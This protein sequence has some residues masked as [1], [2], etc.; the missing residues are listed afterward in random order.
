[1]NRLF[2][3]MLFVFAVLISCQT[4]ELKTEDVPEE[5]G[6]I[7]GEEIE[8]LYLTAAEKFISLKTNVFAFDLLRTVYRDEEEEK[9]ILLSP[10]SASLALAMLNNGAAGQTQQ[11]IQRTLGYDDI[12]REEMN[13]YFQKLITAAQEADPYV[14]F[15]S[16]NSIWTRNDF[17]VL[18]AFKEVNKSYYG[19]EIRSVDF[20]DPET[21]DLIN[22][23]CAEKTNDKIKEILKEVKPGA[24]MYLLNALYFKSAW[25]WPFD[26]E[27]T[28]NERFYNFDGTSPLLP[29]MQM[30]KNLSYGTNESYDLLELPYGKGLFSMILLLPKGEVTL[31]SVIGGLDA[32]TWEQNLSGLFPA[33]VEV[34]LP[35]FKVE[36]ER[37]MTDDLKTLGMPS[38]FGSEADFSLIHPGI[39]VSDVKQKTFVE[40]NEEGTEAAAVTIIDMEMTALPDPEAYRFHVNRPFLYFIKEKSSGVIFFVGAM[41]NL[42]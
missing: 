33:D 26:K 32:E 36:Y 34:K 41:K 21:R 20:G 2:I 24:V 31:S 17:P 1:M 12:T 42:Q 8:P 9:N 28:R 35:R 29:T 10:L 14:T 7:S 13:G 22:A 18:E 16:A 27:E 4:D 6:Y 30:Q 39:C 38:A 23:W 40:V 19:A 11:E 37:Q 3:A 5:P 15:R 25:T